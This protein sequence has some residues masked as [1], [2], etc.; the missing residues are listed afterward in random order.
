MS[1]KGKKMIATI[2]LNISD[3]YR[4]LAIQGEPL[5][6]YTQDL[7]VISIQNYEELEKAKHN[8]EYMEEID[9]R[10]ERLASGKGIHK[11]MEELRAM[12]NE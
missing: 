1:G 3:E 10:M 7:V 11:T 12:E 2:S 5:F 9:K 6:D 4:K 8:A